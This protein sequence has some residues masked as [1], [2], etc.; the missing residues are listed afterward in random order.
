ME[1]ELKFRT[2]DLNKDACVKMIKEAGGVFLKEDVE[3]DIYFNVSGRDSYTTKE[4]L[5]IRSSSNNFAEMTYKPPT[6]KGAID[7]HYAK[8]ETNI[9]VE[10]LE[11][12]KKFLIL[13]GN[14]VLV[15][16][17]KHRSYFSFMECVVCVDYL[18]KVGVFLE[19]EA[20][21]EDRQ[22]GLTKIERCAK[23]LRFSEENIERKPYRDLVWESSK[24]ISALYQRGKF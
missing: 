7:K 4:C 2:N 18:E 3:S 14:E 8:E 24:K 6:I 5:R 17:I 23:V 16:V 22:V 19:I 13:L 11:V 20:N 10:D 1:I 15:Y 12:A 9:R 21:E